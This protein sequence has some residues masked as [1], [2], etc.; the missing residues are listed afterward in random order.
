MNSQNLSHVDNISLKKIR[1]NFSDSHCVYKEKKKLVQ[2]I[3]VS[4][5]KSLEHIEKKKLSLIS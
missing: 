3:T 1:C 2:L 4:I 5:T